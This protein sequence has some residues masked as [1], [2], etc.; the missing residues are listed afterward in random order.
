[1]PLRAAQPFLLELDG[2]SAVR[3]QGDMRHEVATEP[4]AVGALDDEWPVTVAEQVIDGNRAI[5]ARPGSP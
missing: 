1:M 5:R 2:D 4:G 3:V